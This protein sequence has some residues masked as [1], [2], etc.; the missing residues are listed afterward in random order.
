MMVDPV[1]DS[2]VDGIDG[3]CDTVL[4]PGMSRDLFRANNATVNVTVGLNPPKTANTRFGNNI[5]GG[6]IRWLCENIAE[7]IGTWTGWYQV[8]CDNRPPDVKFK[9]DAIAVRLGWTPTFDTP[10]SAAG[11]MLA[12]TACRS[13]TRRRASR[14]TG[15]A[16]YATMSPFGAPRRPA[17]ASGDSGTRCG[18]RTWWTG[19]SR[20]DR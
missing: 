1:N 7:P 2:G 8:N 17:P 14:E 20:A 10:I 5:F 12:A 16:Q 6:I 4:T 11:D 13:S 19:S 9:V 3:T 15:A 18:T